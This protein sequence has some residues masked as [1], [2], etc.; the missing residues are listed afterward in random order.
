MG[1]AFISCELVLCS[2]AFIASAACILDLLRVR[3]GIF[4]ARMG[5]TL[6]LAVVCRVLVFL[7]AVYQISWLRGCM[8]AKVAADSRVGQA[9]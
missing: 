5:E 3:G 4:S 1:A 7:L 2:S 8:D 6:E 9:R